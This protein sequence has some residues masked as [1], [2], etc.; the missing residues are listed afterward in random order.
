MTGAVGLIL[1]VAAYFASIEIIF[2][3]YYCRRHSVRMFWMRA[4]CLALAVL[5]FGCIAS[6]PEFSA[7]NRVLFWIVL[8]IGIMILLGAWV[9]YMSAGRGLYLVHVEDRAAVIAGCGYEFLKSVPT[10]KAAQAAATAAA[11]ASLENVPD[12]ARE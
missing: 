4:V 2:R 3:A 11:A 5:G 7:S 12:C 10:L 9:L 1:V 6:L 8:S